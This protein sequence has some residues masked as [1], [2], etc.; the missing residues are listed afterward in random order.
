[1]YCTVCLL[2]APGGG[3][4]TALVQVRLVLTSSRRRICRQRW[5]RCGGGRYLPE[6]RSR[7][8]PSSQSCGRTPARATCACPQCT[9]AC[10]PAHTSPASLRL[11]VM[12]SSRHQRPSDA[13]GVQGWLPQ[14]S[15]MERS[16]SSLRVANPH[17]PTSLA[18]CRWLPL[19]LLQARL[20]LRDRLAR[21]WLRPGWQ[22]M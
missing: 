21:R 6:P 22:V 14:T 16:V 3:A 9:L 2:S 5:R 17:E 1:M 15:R 13:P 18:A 11:G 10:L 7:L 20:F 4:S 19:L 12:R 8:A